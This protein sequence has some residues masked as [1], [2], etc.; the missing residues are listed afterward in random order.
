MTAI[1]AYQRVAALADEPPPGAVVELAPGTDIAAANRALHAAG[2][3]TMRAVGIGRRRWLLT[4]GETSR[5]A[6]AASASGHRA[7]VVPVHP[8]DRDRPPI[9]SR[10]LAWLM[11]PMEV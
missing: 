4:T 11:R 6:R 7:P 2:I 8:G 1:A 5:Q 9:T 10:A 3:T